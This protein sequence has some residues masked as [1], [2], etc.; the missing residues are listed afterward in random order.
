MISYHRE[1]IHSSNIFLKARNFQQSIL[2]HIPLPIWPTCPFGLHVLCFFQG[3]TCLFF[4]F[5]FSLA[6][7]PELSEARNLMENNTVEEIK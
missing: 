2:V 6:S 3:F 5:N 4:S 7:N 1:M